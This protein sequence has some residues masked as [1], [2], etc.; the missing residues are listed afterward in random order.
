MH[1]PQRRWRTRRDH[2][3]ERQR[4]WAAQWSEP[5]VLAEFLCRFVIFFR[6]RRAGSLS[7]LLLLGACILELFITSEQAQQSLQIWHREP[8]M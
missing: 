4:A 2:S 3:A 7:V 5:L 8:L 6:K 1:T